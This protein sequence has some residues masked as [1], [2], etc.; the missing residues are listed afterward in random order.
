MESTSKFYYSLF[1]VPEV[2]E[3]I[4]WVLIDYFSLKLLSTPNAPTALVPALMDKAQRR[5][6]I[7]VH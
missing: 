2:S 6:V 7:F 3:M 5:E 1:V 4:T